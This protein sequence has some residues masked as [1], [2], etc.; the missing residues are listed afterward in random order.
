V[1][2]AR[3]IGVGEATHGT[4][5]FFALK[6][7]II[8]EI[9]AVHPD[10]VVAVEANMP[11]A[12][13]MNDYVSQGKGDPKALL[14]GMYC[15]CFKT[16]EMLSLV[17]WMREENRSRK[18]HLEFAGFDMQNVSLP[19]A[20]VK[21]Y[22]SQHNAQSAAKADQIYGK[23]QVIQSAPQPTDPAVLNSLITDSRWIETLVSSAPGKR[24]TQQL[25]A[26][27][28]AH[29][30]TQYLLMNSGQ[31]SR[32]ESMAENVEWIASRNRK[33]LVVVWAHNGHITYD[34]DAYVSMGTKLRGFYG[35]RLFTF[36]FAF[37]QGSFNAVSESNRVASFSVGPAP[38]DTLDDALA[39]VGSD[40]F[41]LDLRAVPNFGPAFQWANA[42]HASRNIGGQY[43]DEDDPSSIVSVP[44]VRRFDAIVFV[45]RTSAAVPLP[46]E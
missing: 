18:A 29:L 9:S 35:T 14:R 27:R 5:E 11:E 45:K 2:S 34:G 26:A 41:I 3:I 7:R 19:M 33:A 28:M 1:G 37:D 44:I 30:V 8:Q 17:N 38:P 10:L 32:D 15:W 20:Q 16:E 6:Q 40:A 12:A 13:L 23:V 4:H 24:N 39:Q 42:E 31:Q 46:R 43:K 21:A 36:G 25:W 22:L